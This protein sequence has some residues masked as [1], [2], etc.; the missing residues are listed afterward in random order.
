MINNLTEWF[1]SLSGSEQIIWAIAI[2]SLGIFILQIILSLI[3]LDADLEA[4]FDMDPSGG[5]ALISFRTIISFLVF[6]SWT[7]GILLNQGWN[8]KLAL[9]IGALC[10]LISMFMVAY[11]LYKMIQ[12]EESGNI[13][14][15][16]IIG[17]TGEVYIPIPEGAKAPGRVTIVVDD[18]NM[19]MDAVSEDSVRTGEKVRID[20]ILKNNMLKVSKIK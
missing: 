9:V 10:G 17:S 14:L 13:N 12:M 18:K 5:F 4:D 11:L 2:V 15:E 16:Q 8:F 19:E 20:Q 3:G 6:F 7:S 1:S